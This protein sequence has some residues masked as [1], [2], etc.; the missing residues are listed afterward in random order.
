MANR[1]EGEPK[2]ESIDVVEER[3]KT[4]IQERGRDLTSFERE[5][6]LPIT[7]SD[8]QVE[9]NKLAPAVEQMFNGANN[10]INTL[11]EIKNEDDKVRIK[12]L[13][14]QFNETLQP[15]RT[16]EETKGK[17]KEQKRIRKIL[18]TIIDQA[19]K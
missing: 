15:T 6:L 3:N 8:G 17:I 18:D 13:A 10:P 2:F 7:G 9:D 5:V 4:L 19:T 16:A 12:A 11:G 14:A 1:H